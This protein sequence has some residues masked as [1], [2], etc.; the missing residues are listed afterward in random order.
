MEISGLQ[1]KLQMEF[2]K[3]VMIDHSYKLYKILDK[4]M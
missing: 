4:D 1:S 3:Q 2:R